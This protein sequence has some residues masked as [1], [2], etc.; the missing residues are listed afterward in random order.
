MDRLFLPIYARLL[1]A[2]VAAVLAIYIVVV[3]KIQARV[4]RN[5]TA[6]LSP[7]LSLIA[8]Q[9]DRELRADPSRPPVLDAGDRFEVPV[10]VISRASA[11][12]D[13]RE[14]EELDRGD[15][16][17]VGNV[18][19][20]TLFA[21]VG[22]TEHVLRWGPLAPANPIGEER[23][24]MLVLLVLLGLFFG[25]YLLLL[26]IQRRLK[27]LGGV[28]DELG[29]GRLETRAKDDRSDAIGRL[30]ATFNRMAAQL[31]RLLEAQEELLRT[32]SHELRTPLQRAHLALEVVESASESEATS[33]AVSRMERSLD[34]I[35]L[36]IEELLTYVRLKGVGPSLVLVDVRA[37]AE[38]LCAAAREDQAGVEVSLEPSLEPSPAIEAELDERLLRRALGNLISNAV[39]HARSRVSVQLVRRE[40]G[41]SISVEDDG[42]GVPAEE[43]ELIFEPFRTIARGSKS[44]SGHGLGLAIV[45]R[46]AELHRGSIAVAPAA[47]GGARF[48][49]DLPAS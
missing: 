12:L 33:G 2:M 48:Q 21:R 37:V 17:V 10:R 49:L 34:E 35:D 45:R 11:E 24:L 43:R 27:A 18:P 4:R 36:L 25:A 38:E 26:P 39:K 23:G 13:R 6:A 7:T 44:A 14:V 28:A 47:L 9:M 46:I 41:V 3:P 42:P 30:G 15:I 20:L 8:D 32:V 31:Q 16:V 19:D 22:Q 40:N 5:F 29:R 1:A